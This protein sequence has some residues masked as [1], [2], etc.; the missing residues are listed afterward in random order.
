MIGIKIPGGNIEKNAADIAKN[1]ELL[2]EI[3]FQAVEFSPDSFDLIEC[4]VINH[5][6]L[7]ELA[8]LLADFPVKP[9][10]HAP[11]RLNLFNREHPQ[12][13]RA[14]LEASYQIAEVLGAEILVYHPGRSI[15]NVEFLRMGRPVDA[16]TF[17]AELMDY[18]AETL[19]DSAAS[20]P[21]ITIAMENHRPYLEYSP[22]SYAEFCTELA[23]RITAINRPNIR[24]CID[25][26]H[27]NLTAAY[28]RRDI[29]EEL[30]AL[31]RHIA[32]CHIHDNH[33]I[34]NYYTDKDKSGMLPFGLG[35][36]HIVPGRGT[37]AFDRFFPVMAGYQG[38][39]MVELTGRA[40][41]PSQ[42]RA[43]YERVQE[44]HT[45]ALPPQTNKAVVL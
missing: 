20:H 42:I 25:T 11:L 14:V 4:G 27:L 9:V 2:A 1:L 21:S 16:V 41:Y 17:S 40:F 26:G 34:T 15:D 36:E 7:R 35:D 24:A 6:L 13:H 19:V 39:Y 30:T 3:G 45:A 28:H 29:V 37:F 5:A 18:E 23:A 33:A 43:A 31:R 12:I 32:H 10:I 38:I 8:I 44:L 22:Y